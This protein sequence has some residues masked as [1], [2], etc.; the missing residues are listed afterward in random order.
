MSSH[1]ED[2]ATKKKLLRAKNRKQFIINKHLEA[3][4]EN[5]NLAREREEEMRE[6]AKQASRSE[7]VSRDA[8]GNPVWSAKM[9]EMRN[10][11]NGKKRM[12]KDRWNRFAG[13]SGAGGM[14]R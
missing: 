6:A 8:D 14:G 2:K 1:S 13:T 7:T 10:K 3:Q 4:E 12:A 11:V 5:R 9:Q